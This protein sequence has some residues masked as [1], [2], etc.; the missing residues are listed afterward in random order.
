MNYTLIRSKR[1]LRTISLRVNSSGELIV[2]SPYFTPRLVIDKFVKEKANWIN[3][4][5]KTHHLPLAK[6]SQSEFI[7]KSQ[8]LEAYINSRLPTLAETIGVKY[9]SVEIKN[10]TSYWGNCS[11][12]GLLR[13]NARLIDFENSV[14]DYVLVH[15]LSHIKH[16]GHDRRFWQFLSTHYPDHKQARKVLRSSSLTLD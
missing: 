1:R 10:V 13:F 5:K 11:R 6:L 15:E 2:R 8:K 16:R 3:Q 4:R 9:M 12:G 7:S 14:I